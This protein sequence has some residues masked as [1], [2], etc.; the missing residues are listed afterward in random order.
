MCSD[1][2]TDRHLL[3][4]PPFRSGGTERV[5]QVILSVNVS[6]ERRNDMAERIAGTRTEISRDICLFALFV[7]NLIDQFELENREIA[8][9]QS[10][11]TRKTNSLDG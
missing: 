10:K 3:S 8:S 4:V 9:K 2:Q 6:T 7:W 5:L 11:Q 1:S